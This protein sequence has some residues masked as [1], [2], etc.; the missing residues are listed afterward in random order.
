[1]FGILSREQVVVPDVVGVGVWAYDEVNVRWID[2][3][4]LEGKSINSFQKK[5]SLSLTMP[6]CILKFWSINPN[7]DIRA[8]FL[9]KAYQNGEKNLATKEGCSKIS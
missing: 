5:S 8:K 9:E 1:M 6:P 4:F 2:I 3:V 7:L